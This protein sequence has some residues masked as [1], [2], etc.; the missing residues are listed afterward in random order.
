MSLRTWVTRK[1][2]G[3]TGEWL[4]GTVVKVLAELVVSALLGGVLTLIVVTF[5]PT[6]ALV[7]VIPAEADRARHVPLAHDTDPQSVGGV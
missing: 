1:R 6:R 3:T 4:A 5:L 7:T 2:D